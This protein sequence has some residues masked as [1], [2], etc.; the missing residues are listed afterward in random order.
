MAN[1]VLYML[2]KKQSCKARLLW[3]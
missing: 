2:I 3:R 1:L